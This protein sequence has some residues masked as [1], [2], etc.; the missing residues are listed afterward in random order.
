M[1]TNDDFITR[2]EHDEFVKRIEDSEK[3]Q[4]KRIDELEESVKD[5]TRLT[6]SIEKIATKQDYMITEQ[7]RQGEVLAKAQEKIDQLEK[8]PMKDALETSKAIKKKTTETVVTVI[9]TALVVALI[10][11]VAQY[12]K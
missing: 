12:V 2:R 9:V 8:E 6:A 10:I 5:I 11:L 1:P 3:R 4:N 7:A